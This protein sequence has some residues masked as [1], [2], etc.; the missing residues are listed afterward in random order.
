MRMIAEE[1][2][3]G[4]IEL[5]LTKPLT[6]WQVIT[7][8]F[9]SGLVLI[10]LTLALTLPYYFTVAALGEIDHGAV[11]CGYLGLLLMSAVYLSIGLYTSSVSNNQIVALL[12]ALFIG[13]FFH[14]IFGFLA[15]GLKGSVGEVFSYISLS[16]H[17]ESVAR[18]VIDTKD[19]VYFF[20]LIFLGLVATEANM[21]KRH[22]SD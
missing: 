12:L 20:S 9:L 18:G 19:L 17:F 6:D 21:S 13:V 1:K 15:S 8:K 3:S 22:I 7:G 14:L 2:K 5:L 11:W 4:T 10:G 16:D